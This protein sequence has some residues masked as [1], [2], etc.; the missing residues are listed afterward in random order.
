MGVCGFE[1]DAQLPWVAPGLGEDEAALNGGEGRG[2]QPNRVGGSFELARL[3]HLL[4][5]DA[6]R[7]FPPVEPVGQLLA[8]QLVGFGELGGEAADR[9]ATNAV[10]RDLEGDESVKPC[11][12]SPAPTSPPAP[13]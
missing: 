1:R 10:S 7:L 11:R 4:E 6:Q 12:D 13:R 8:C 9:A 3:A 5:P 2:G